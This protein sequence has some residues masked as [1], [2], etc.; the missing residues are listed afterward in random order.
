MNATLETSF[1]GPVQVRILRLV[2]IND[3][4]CTKTYEV[5]VT[6]PTGNYPK[7]LVL[8]IPAYALWKRHRF[9]GVTR[10]EWSGRP[11]LSKFEVSP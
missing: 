4:T 5:E 1:S 3:L 8:H 9:F 7:G 6:K 2:G 10:S 11:D